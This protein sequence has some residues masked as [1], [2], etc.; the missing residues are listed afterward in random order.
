MV[1]MRKDKNHVE[2]ME[3]RERRREAVKSW[4]SLPRREQSGERLRGL[5]CE[6]ASVHFEFHLYPSAG[7]IPQLGHSD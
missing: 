4:G 1:V 6:H 5:P 7:W 3:K 2:G